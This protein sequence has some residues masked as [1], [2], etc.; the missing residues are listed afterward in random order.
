MSYAREQLGQ[1]PRSL[2][3]DLQARGKDP[4]RLCA[5]RRR[6]VEAGCPEGR[7]KEFTPLQ[8]ILLDEKRDFEIQRDERMK[9]LTLPL[10]QFDSRAGREEQD[11]GETGL[12]ADL[13]PEIGKLRRAQAQ[14]EQQIALLRHVE[15]LRLYS[16][17]HNGRLPETLADVA[18]PLPDDPVSGKPFAC[19][20]AGATAQ[21]RGSVLRGEEKGRGY[22]VRYEVNLQ[23]D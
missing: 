6:L 11:E 18:V 15:A 20:V 1:S 4:E 21:F 14:L 9:Q 3:R 17:E 16:S 19:T 12:F 13:L 5:A 10:W 23:R 2:R 7:V 8:I 22:S